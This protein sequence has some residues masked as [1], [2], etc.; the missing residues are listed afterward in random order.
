MLVRSA[1][2]VAEK[3]LSY[4]LKETAAIQI[5]ADLIDADT[6]PDNTGKAVGDTHPDNT[7]KAVGERY[8]TMESNCVKNRR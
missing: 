1:E 4:F 6:H 5:S 8:R 7:G 2:Y 3:T